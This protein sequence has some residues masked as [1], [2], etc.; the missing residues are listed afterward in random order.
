VLLIAPAAAQAGQ[1][2]A[3]AAAVDASWHVGASAGQYAS[4]GSFVGEDTGVD[5]T[6]HSTR[7]RSSYGIQSRL[8]VRAL[9]VEGANG[10]RVALV[11]NDL[12]IPQ[13]LLYRRTAQILEQR[14]TSG[15]TRENLTVAVTHNHSSPLY[16][17]PSWGVWAFQD[18]I[19]VRFFNYYARRMATAVERAAA[20]MEPVRVGARVVEFDKTHRHSF[21]PAV[22]DD[23]TPAGYPNEDADHS[24]AVVRFDS[25]GGKTL[26]TLVNFSLHPEFLEGNDLV[27]GDYVAPLQR[28]VDRRTGGVTIWTQNAVGTA[29]PERSSYHSLHE[30]LEFTHR[31]YAQAEYGA[32]LMA[33]AV[34]GAWSAIPELRATEPGRAVPMSGDFPVEMQDRWYP[35]PISHPYP[36][37]SNCRTD[38]AFEGNPQ[39]PVV[40]LPDC[41]GPRNNPVG[42]VFAP[43][44]DTFGPQSPGL[45]T[46]DLQRAGIPVPE[47]YSAPSYTGL[48]EDLGVHLQAFRLGDMLF[49]I[50]SCEQ[51]KDQAFNIKTRTDREAGNEYLGY[52]WKERCTPRGDGTYGI[53]PEGYG[54]GT[55]DCPDPRSPS[56]TL[57]PLPD[58][59]VQRMHAQVTNPANGWNEP[60]YAPFAESEPADVRQIKGNYT[61]DD[62]ARSAALGYD[63]TVPIAMANDYNGY[64]ASYREYQNRDHYRKALTGWGPHSSDYIATRLVWMARRFRDRDYRV[65]DSS[66][67]LLAAKTKPDLAFQDAKAQ[68][69]GEI[70]AGSARA[71]DE[72]LP[73]SGGKPEPVREPDDLERFGAALFTWNGGDN[74]TDNPRVRVQRRTGR[75]WVGWEDQSGEIP[76]IVRYPKAEEL[77]AYLA[78]GQRWHWTA[79]FEAFAA[80]FDTGTGRSYTPAGAYR[81]V[82][83]GRRREADGVKRYRVRSR[84]FRV[85]PWSG[86]T[87]DDLRVEPDGTV[88]FA[89][90]PRHS[91]EVGDPPFAAEVGPI[92]YPDSYESPVRFIRDERTPFPDPAAP[93][94]PAKIEWYCFTCTFR[95][96][97]DSGDAASA[98]FTFTRGGRSR[99]VR[100]V[101]RDGRW[102]SARALR[103][104][105]TAIVPA[106]AVRDGW[107][108][109]N[110]EASAELTR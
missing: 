52:D 88:S 99:T 16:S 64:I 34:L 41:Q 11:K 84:A 90:G 20:R 29:E 53:G 75:G 67:D 15:I 32:R 91:Y 38:R 93:R 71:Y 100:A 42:D 55:W 44:E 50:C 17:S 1:V 47:N 108:D 59:D 4:D 69:I 40:G 21:G 60:A 73:A 25:L 89:V 61:H 107:R 86:I 22:A 77:P 3:G 98:H 23:G 104:G 68:A 36:G 58:G 101:Q 72:M 103:P 27:S 70:G 57:P 95:P 39:V 56:Q 62:D 49:T 7:R 78:G 48:E 106:G 6:M 65:T 66:D 30:R 26:A 14:G 83:R 51:W 12:Y 87:V 63:L 97:L 92:D 82:V 80:P 5:P 76:V 13:D 54:T 8:S 2:Q 37:V 105:E 28:M 43:V 33:D 18:V 102:H 31:D 109:Y 85:R 81:F 35:G 9:V 79:T 19:D 46:D 96:W 74:Y 10:G 24:L 94:D 45:T 110:G